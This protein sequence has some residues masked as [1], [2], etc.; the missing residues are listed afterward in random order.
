MSSTLSVFLGAVLV[1]FLVGAV[2]RHQD[3]RR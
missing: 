1:H 3:R 2:A